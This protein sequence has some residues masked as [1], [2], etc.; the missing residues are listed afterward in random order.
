MNPFGYFNPYPLCDFIV[1]RHGNISIIR[2]NQTFKIRWLNL[3]QFKHINKYNWE[4][5]ANQSDQPN[6]ILPS[7]CLK[8][9]TMDFWQ[10]HK[11]L[12]DLGTDAFDWCGCLI[13][14][15]SASCQICRAQIEYYETKEQLDTIENSIIDKLQLVDYVISIQRLYR[16]NIRG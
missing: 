14:G 6:Y 8:G 1:N 9:S 12:K 3:N 11:T 10:N 15:H 5:Y 2:N 7:D 16:S 4:D 13:G